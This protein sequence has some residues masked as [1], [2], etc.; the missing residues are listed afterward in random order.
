MT[1]ILIDTSGSM[2]DTRRV[3]MPVEETTENTIAQRSALNLVE[4]FDKL[5]EHFD[6]T[7]LLGI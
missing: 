3:K 2:M 1:A 4:Q 5:P 6:Q 7:I